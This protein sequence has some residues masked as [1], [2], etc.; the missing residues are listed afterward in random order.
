M[1][2]IKTFETQFPNDTKVIE[3]GSSCMF[4]GSRK[5]KIIERNGL[6][7]VE[8]RS[9]FEG[10]FDTRLEAKE[11]QRLRRRADVARVELAA[12]EDSLYKT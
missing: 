11:Y 2:Q 10:P 8:T 3:Q 1:I 9:G 7:F 6:W 5:N 4:F 12:L